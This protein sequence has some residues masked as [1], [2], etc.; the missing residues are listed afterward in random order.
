VARFQ[1]TLWARISAA[2]GGERQAQNEF[3][4]RYRAPLLSYLRLK[5]VPEPEDMAQEVFLR[6]FAQ[7]LLER[8][9]PTRGRFRSYLLA[10]TRNVLSEQQRKDHALKRGR[11]HTRVLLTDAVAVV[12]DP[13]FDACWCRDLL[14]RALAVLRPS[15]PASTASWSS[16]SSRIC[17]TKRS[18]S[19]FKS[20]SNTSE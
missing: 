16:A 9:D 5:R 8:V 4:T 2:R 12:E 1:T 20:P 6:V 13:G 17:P 7:D 15:T 10:I 18:P 3:V 19:G 14:E 11:D